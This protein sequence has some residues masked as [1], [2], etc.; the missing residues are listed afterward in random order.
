MSGLSLADHDR[1]S[2]A[3]PGLKH[4]EFLA[5]D[6]S[7]RSNETDMFSLR[8]A[9]RDAAMCLKVLPHLK[10]IIIFEY[11]FSVA[12]T[13]TSESRYDR[14]FHPNV[15]RFGFID[16]KVKYLDRTFNVF[17]PCGLSFF[18]P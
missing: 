10:W 7:V 2:E 13:I 12:T 9:E 1:V 11:L 4:L 18:R 6:S 15:T 3:L 17:R 5:L 14:L 8:C 16:V